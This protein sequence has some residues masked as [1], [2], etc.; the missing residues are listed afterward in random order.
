MGMWDH[1][2]D[3]FDILHKA[4]LVLGELHPLP[5]PF[6]LNP[7]LL[8][9]NPPPPPPFPR[10]LLCRPQFDGLHPTLLCLML[11][12]NSVVSAIIVV[13]LAVHGYTCIETLHWDT[14]VQQ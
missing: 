10:P 9:P 11:Q 7:P 2:A 4:S 8:F 6:P 5:S 1:H 13:P 12:P 3:I 14:S